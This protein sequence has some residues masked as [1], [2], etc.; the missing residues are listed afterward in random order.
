MAVLAAVVV[1]GAVAIFYARAYYDGWL[2]QAAIIS[3]AMFAVGSTVVIYRRMV[4]AE[5]KITAPSVL[6]RAND[7]AKAIHS[8]TLLISDLQAEM[9]LRT[10]ALERIQA[11][12]A[13]FERLA[14]VHKEEAEAVTNL[15]ESVISSTHAKMN[16]QNLQ[17]QLLFFAVGLL[18]S[19]PIGVMVNLATK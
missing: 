2:L 10:A 5:R 14:T 3:F 16:R 17:S 11:E 12:S 18:F 1:V 6:D 4:R 15:V 7:A 9:G 19:I 13:E 8:A